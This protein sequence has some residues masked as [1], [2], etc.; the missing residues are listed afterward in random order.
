[1]RPYIYPASVKPEM[2][3]FCNKTGVDALDQKV[4]LQCMLQDM[5]VSRRLLQHLR[6]ICT[7][8][9]CFIPDAASSC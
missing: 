4:I 9:L 7:Q 8:C 6:Y 1:M 5:L 2:L 3:K